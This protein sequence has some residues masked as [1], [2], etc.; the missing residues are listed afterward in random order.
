M[1][2]RQ[3]RIE[4]RTGRWAIHSAR[5]ALAG[6]ESPAVMET[7]HQSVPHAQTAMFELYSGLICLG[8]P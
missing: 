6:R 3:S 2:T 5:N 7:T 1:S 4:S 8:Y